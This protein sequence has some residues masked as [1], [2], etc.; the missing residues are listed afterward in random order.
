MYMLSVDDTVAVEG[1]S[2]GVQLGLWV[3]EER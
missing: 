3:D 2:A 1:I